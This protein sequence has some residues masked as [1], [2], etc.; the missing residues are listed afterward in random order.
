MDDLICQT[1]GI[2]VPVAY[3]FTFAVYCG[4]TGTENRRL[5]TEIKQSCPLSFDVGV[6]S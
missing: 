2:K 4:R 1:I 5:G 3:D 6:E